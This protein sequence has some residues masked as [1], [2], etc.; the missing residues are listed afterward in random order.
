[1]FGKRSQSVRPRSMM[2]RGTFNHKRQSMPGWK[3]F[4][5]RKK[6][7]KITKNK[8][9][10][11]LIAFVIAYACIFFVTTPHL[12]IDT[13]VISGYNMIPKADFSDEVERFLSEKAFRVF[14][15]RQYWFAD[16]N[17]LSNK[18]VSKF[19]LASATVKKHYPNLIEVQI[20]EGTTK[21]VLVNGKEEYFVSMNGTI[22]IPVNDMNK[23][24]K[25]GLPR[26]VVAFDPIPL[27]KLAEDQELMST[28]LTEIEKQELIKFFADIKTVETASAIQNTK[29]NNKNVSTD[30]LDVP[31][32]NVVKDGNGTYVFIPKNPLIMIGDALF[33]DTT[34]KAITRLNDLVPVA[35]N[36]SIKEYIIR[37]IAE[38]NTVVR[39]ILDNG[40]EIICDPMI[41]LDDQVENLTEAWPKF[42]DQLGSIKYIDLRFD[43]FIYY[44]KK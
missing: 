16:T 17:V 11:T 39:I 32:P 7:Q 36:T 19:N 27:E 25:N 3:H 38:K 21:L 30:L 28:Y 42:M 34:V 12:K 13:V 14:S 6:D 23:D 43:N 33:A 35:V 2:Y 18:L 44:K 9:I 31:L 5:A 37:S 22:S 15:H 26:V 8:I 1:M 20:D 40:L 29:S 4:E 24:K 10:Y 41:S